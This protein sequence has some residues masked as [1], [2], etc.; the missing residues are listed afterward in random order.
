[1]LFAL[2][3]GIGAGKSTVARLLAVRGAIIVDADV[4]ARRIVD[5]SD[6]STRPVLAEIRALLGEGVFVADGTLDRP[7]VASI[8]FGDDTALAAYNAILRSALIAKTSSTLTEAV[9][10]G[11]GASVVHEIPLLNAGSAPLPWTYD[12][13][14]TVEAPLEERLRRLIADRGYSREEASARIIAHGSEESRAEL[15]DVVLHNDGSR[16]DLEA[17][18]DEL[19]KTWTGEKPV[20]S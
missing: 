7:A 10:R 2:T 8:V 3:G 5:P 1:M 16:A 17:R 12:A 14:A 13:V 19:W 6:P 4:I 9:A 20:E 18:V 15:A 11:S